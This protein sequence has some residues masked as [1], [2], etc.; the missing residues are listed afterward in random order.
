M[1]GA[2]LKTLLQGKSWAEGAS[3]NRREDLKDCQAKV[4]LAREQEEVRGSEQG[5]SYVFL[6]QSLVPK[7]RMKANPN[8]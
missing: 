1:P 7:P 5:C 8:P 4:L 6:K 3:R 2:A